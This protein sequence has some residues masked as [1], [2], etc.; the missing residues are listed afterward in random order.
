M[1]MRDS[2]MK[3]RLTVPIQN[4]HPCMLHLKERT[5]VRCIELIQSDTL[6]TNK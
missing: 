2:K 1:S 3:A 4:Y 5:A 6:F